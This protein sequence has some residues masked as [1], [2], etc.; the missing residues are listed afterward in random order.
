M[1]VL[2]SAL[3]IHPK[4]PGLWSYAAH[5][6]FE[7]NQNPSGARSLMQQGLRACKEDSQLWL[8]YLKMELVYAQKLVTRRDILGISQKGLR[9][10]YVV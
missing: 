2:A 8:D 9:S 5:W 6:E 7:E 4:S 1:Q 10:F 3:Q